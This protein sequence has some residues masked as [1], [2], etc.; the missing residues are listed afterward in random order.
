MTEHYRFTRTDNILHEATT[1]DST[2]ISV[3]QS[4]VTES[5]PCA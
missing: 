2:T 1:D 3:R 5:P 4:H